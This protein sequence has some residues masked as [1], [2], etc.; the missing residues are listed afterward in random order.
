MREWLKSIKQNLDLLRGDVGVSADIENAAEAIGSGITRLGNALDRGAKK[1]LHFETA[2]DLCRK[3]GGYTIHVQVLAARNL[4]AADYAKRADGGSSDPF[5]VL[6]MKGDN[7]YRTKVVSKELNPSWENESVM[8]L[9]LADEA[10]ADAQTLEVQVKT[11]RKAKFMGAC[12]VNVSKL[13]AVPHVTKGWF[14]L[15]KDK[16]GKA[17]TGLGEVELAITIGT[18]ALLA[19]NHTQDYVLTHS[20]GL[21]PT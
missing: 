17:A 19:K 20:Y 2:A 18:R 3:D 7:E 5:V 15:D 12:S 8:A 14:A 9:K 16:S 13:Q 4:K 11:K 1:L 6:K 21:R 10:A